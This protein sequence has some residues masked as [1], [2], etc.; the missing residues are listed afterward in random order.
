MLMTWPNISVSRYH[1]SK[2]II[3]MPNIFPKASR[4]WATGQGARGGA[5]VKHIIYLKSWH[6][7]NYRF[8]RGRCEN[9]DENNKIEQ[10]LMSTLVQKKR[11]K[12][13]GGAWEAGNEN[14]PKAWRRRRWRRRRL[15]GGNA[16]IRKKEN[17]CA[18]ENWTEGFA[19]GWGGEGCWVWGVNDKQTSDVLRRRRRLRLR[20]RPGVDKKNCQSALKVCN[21]SKV[22]CKI[23]KYNADRQLLQLLLPLL[24]CYCNNNIDSAFAS[25]Q[26]AVGWR[27]YKNGHEG[28]EVLPNAAL[29]SPPT[30]MP[31]LPPVAGIR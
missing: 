25:R 6:K 14:K 26:S 5:N 24:H 2:V 3:I 29:S 7:Y 28:Q 16:A 12:K 22:S 30:P 23:D 18:I 20:L 1:K 21:A 31:T 10:K 8:E 11:R 13:V 17:C 19:L 27:R 9:E 15:R 4:G